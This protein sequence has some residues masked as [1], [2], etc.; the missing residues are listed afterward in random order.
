MFQPDGAIELIL[1]KETYGP[2]F[3]YDVAMK[4][5]PPAFVA[6][7]AYHTYAEKYDVYKVS[8]RRLIALYTP[9]I[10]EAP[11]TVLD[12][13]CGTGMSLRALVEEFPDS[14]VV[15]VDNSEHMINIAAKE[16]SDVQFVHA[17][18][19]ELG[20]EGLEG[21]DAIFCNAAFWYFD[22]EVALSSIGKA[23]SPDGYLLFNISEPA[24]SFDD[25]NYDD[26][27]LQTM[28]E[29]LDDR[30]IIFHRQGGHGVGRL[31]LSYK[32]P[33]IAEIE[34]SLIG[35]R[36]ST[37][38]SQTWKFTK[39]LSELKDFYSIPGFGTKAFREL[40]DVKLKQDI[41]DETA[42]RLEKDGVR[43]ISFRWQ[44]FV[45]QKL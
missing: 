22:R 19:E 38:K 36:F 39:S 37:I 1:G 10:K 15:A 35:S 4:E 40:T 6:A 7:E 33:S 5:K 44:D 25:N 3:C 26:R 32:P 30:G 12:L 16:Q 23:L 18:V 45:A 29:V 34:Q 2:L 43:E 27:F 21:F 13:G 8:I 17:G 41:L 42:A 31:K 11:R 20:D 28:I 24:I 9:H 14:K